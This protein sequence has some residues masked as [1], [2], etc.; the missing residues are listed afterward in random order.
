MS[1]TARERA[2]H[3]HDVMILIDCTL[4]KGHKRRTCLVERS[5]ASAVSI[6]PL[7][8]TQRLLERGAERNRC[9]LCGCMHE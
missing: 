8:F 7:D 2:C 3:K 4:Q 5:K 6:N 1:M 9:V